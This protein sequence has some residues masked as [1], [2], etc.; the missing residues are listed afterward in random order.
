[1]AVLIAMLLPAFFSFSAE[2]P[3]KGMVLIPAGTFRA[4]Y[5]PEG[6]P[7]RPV[8]AFWLDEKTV[9]NRDFLQF[10]SDN[11]K[12]QRSKVGRLFADES[13]L[14]HWKADLDAGDDDWMDRPVIHVSWF[15]ARAYAKWRGCRLPT[16]DE[17][18]LASA[19]DETRADASREPAFQKRILDWYS[20]P[21][22][23]RPPKSG[24]LYRTLH[25]AR[26]LHG[27]VWEWVEDF[28]AVMI[29]G[30]SRGDVANERGL[31][32]GGGAA[33]STDPGNYAAFMRYAM[34]G[35]LQASYTTANL[36]FRCAKD[37]SP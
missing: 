14:R 23:V 9:T 13:Y 18:E 32:C 6:T 3:P 28:N 27:G 19:A 8:A 35:S 36:G 15:A 33:N 30:E 34:R 5:E 11:P 22:P 29:S 7:A 20:R 25:G 1:L 16:Q 31:F 12:W 2:P 26:D 4:F 24:S 10:V 17:W 21:N 37:P